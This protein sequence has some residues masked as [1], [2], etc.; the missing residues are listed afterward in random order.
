[1]LL[2]LGSDHGGF[3]LKTEI[4]TFL[5]AQG[6][7]VKDFGA[8]SKDPVDYPDIAF[9]VAQAVARGEYE[10]GILVDTT[11]IASAI[12]A[13]KVFGI[14]ATPCA[15]LTTL[16]SSREHN[17][18]NVLCLGAGLVHADQAREFLGVWLSTP[19]AGGRH[20]RR[21]DKI[22]QVEEMTMKRTGVHSVRG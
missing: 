6:H 5:A 14:R 7:S 3:G 21:V 9:L 13:N 12:V 17:D 10:R 8:F 11:G 2:V 16:K 20:A 1:M 18:A 4:K 15:D 22:C 19:F